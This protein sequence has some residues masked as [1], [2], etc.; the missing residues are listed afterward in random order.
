M[1][2]NFEQISRQSHDP[3]SAEYK[4]IRQILID[5]YKKNL[6]ERFG[7]ECI[8]A[9]DIIQH[10]LF[11]AGV[12]SKIV[13][14]QLSLVNTDPKKGFSW[15]FHGYDDDTLTPDR[16]DTH[17]VV[18]TE[19]ETPWIIDISIAHL[20]EGTR[21]WIIEKINGNDPLTIAHYQ[22]DDFTATYHPKTNIK[23]PALHAKNLLDRMKAQI[24]IEKTLNLLKVLVIVLIMITSANFA[25]GIYDYYHTFVVDVDNKN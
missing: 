6:L 18:I 12:N 15:H 22:F 17:V 21:P 11:R 19:S 14:V 24:R 10:N 16:L 7:G 8:A 25:R 13:E 2:Y 23:I 5:L 20:I 3:D 4:K 9:A 1:K